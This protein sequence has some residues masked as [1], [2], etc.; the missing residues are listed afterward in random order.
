[1]LSSSYYRYR[2]TN[3]LVDFP[4]AD[5]EGASS[6]L[7]NIPAVIGNDGLEFVLTTQNIQSPRFVW[8]T[9]CNISLGRN[10]LLY[11][12]GTAPNG[13]QV[14]EPLSLF[15]V[16]EVTGVDPKT[17]T[18][19]FNDGNGNGIPAGNAAARTFPVNT[20]PSCYGGVQNTFRYRQ[21][22]LDVLFQFIKQQGL[23]DIYDPLYLPGFPRNQYHAA[24]DQHWQ[25]A[26]DVSQQQRFSQNGQLR[27]GYN[28]AIQGSMGYTDASFIRCKNVSL[29]W[30]FPYRKLGVKDCKLYLQAQN[31]F[32]ITKYPGM[33]P[34]TQ[35]RTAIPPLR[36]INTG[37]QIT[38]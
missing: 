3:Q 32:T 30:N 25:N 13:N 16:R 26:G 28:M 2:S 8:T 29:A 19:L 31:L 1:M 24:V 11:Y 7:G 5:L 20:V 21:I 38:F 12:P 4:L 33:D 17:G 27:N 15:Y 35:S 37:I 6:I 34:E 9:S 18:Y 22:Q 14:G 36:V 10:K 23:N